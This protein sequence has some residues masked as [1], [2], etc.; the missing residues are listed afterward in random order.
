MEYAIDVGGTKIAYAIVDGCR[1][2]KSEERPTEPSPPQAQFPRVGE[3]LRK[4]A[5]DLGVK[6]RAAGLSLPGPVARDTLLRAPNLHRDWTGKTIREFEGLIGLDVP[7]YAQRDAL[8]GGLGEYACGAGRGLHSFAYLTLGTGVGGGLILEGRPLA[9][10]DG[11]AGEIGHLQVEARG[12]MCGCGRRGCVEAIASG[13][14]IARLYARRGGEDLDAKE[15][16]RRAHAGERLARSVYRKAG[17]ALG[18]AC[19]AWAQV[20]NPQAIIAGGSLAESLDLLQ[21]PLERA[22]SQRAWSANLPLPIVKASL[23]GPAPLIG[24]AYLARQAHSV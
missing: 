4:M 15:I 1:V 22:L 14:S 12:P 24:A 18:A 23:G 7:F 20:A 2:L 19:A 10:A 17:A 5:K 8:L 13:P 6:P 11:A 21:P 16:A 3:A 9:G